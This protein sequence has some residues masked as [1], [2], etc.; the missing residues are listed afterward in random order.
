MQESTRD[1]ARTPSMTQGLGWVQRN[2]AKSHTH[3][4][5][6][7]RPLFTKNN[8]RPPRLQIHYPSLTLSLGRAVLPYADSLCSK[9]ATRTG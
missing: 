2:R 3:V 1:D 4:Y 5:D 9:T 8:P 6:N 7:E